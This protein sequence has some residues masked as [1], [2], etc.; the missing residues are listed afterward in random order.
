MEFNW[1]L[2]PVVNKKHEVVKIK[3]IPFMIKRRKWKTKR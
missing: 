2:V 3:I 1:K